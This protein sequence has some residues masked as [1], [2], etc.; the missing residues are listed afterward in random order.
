MGQYIGIASFIRNAALMSCCVTQWRQRCYYKVLT[1]GR[2]PLGR[3]GL[4]LHIMMAELFQ[5]LA[6][7]CLAFLEF[8]K[9]PRPLRFTIAAPSK[10]EAKKLS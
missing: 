8:L 1:F 6:L 2:S 9:E 4:K 5:W 7:I 10:V 3:V